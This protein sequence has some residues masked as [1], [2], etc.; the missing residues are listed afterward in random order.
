[1]TTFVWVHSF[2]M[3]AYKVLRKISFAETFAFFLNEWSLWTDEILSYLLRK[4]ATGGV[5]FNKVADLQACSFIKIDS[6]TEVFLS[7]LRNF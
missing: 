4:A 6:N 2:R 5:L 1:M 3:R 7:N